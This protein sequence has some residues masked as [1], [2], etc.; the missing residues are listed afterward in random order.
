MTKAVIVE[1]HGNPAGMPVRY[2][3]VN[4]ENISKGTLLILSG[5][6]TAAKS[7]TTTTNK[8]AL[9]VAA[10]DKVASD[11]ST[12]IGVY[13]A[14]I[15]DIVTAGAVVEGDLVFISGQD[16]VGRLRA[17]NTGLEQSTSGANYIPFGVVFGKALET[18]SDA[19][20]ALIKLG[21]Y[22]L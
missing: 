3:C 18:Q 19:T 11:G 10:H 16:S 7:V 2:T 6:K 13:T 1:L 21:G 4:T 22:G 8:P 9:G 12:S 20:A 5:A 15:F 14:G 17:I